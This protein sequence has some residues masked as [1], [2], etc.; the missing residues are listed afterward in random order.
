MTDCLLATS[1][2]DAYI[3]QTRLRF[4]V[5]DG[6]R[7]VGGKVFE[8]KFRISKKQWHY[9]SGSMVEARLEMTSSMAVVGYSHTMGSC[10][11]KRKSLA[12]P[13]LASFFVRHGRSS[14][15]VSEKR[16]GENDKCIDAHY[17]TISRVVGCA[18]KN[19]VCAGGSYTCLVQ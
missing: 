14:L 1:A 4:P 8:Q 17:C 2:A 12:S 11:Q 6:R 13:P 7:K 18:S 10:E 16:V 9:A 15:D 5:I 19:V 3:S